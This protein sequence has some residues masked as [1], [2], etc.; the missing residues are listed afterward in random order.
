MRKDAVRLAVVAALLLGCAAPRIDELSLQYGR[1]YGAARKAE[2][3]GE[4]PTEEIALNLDVAPW[5]PL[6]WRNHV[7]TTTTNGAYRLVGWQHSV[8]AKLWDWGEISLYHHSQHLMDKQQAGAP[9]ENAVMF[10]LFL[11]KAQ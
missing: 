4:T 11:L 6:F 1:Y 8:G 2:M 10:K 5:G 9:L 3:P 7:H